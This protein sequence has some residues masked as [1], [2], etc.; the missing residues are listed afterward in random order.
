[1]FGAAHP[2]MAGAPRPATLAKSKS[3]STGS[4][5]PATSATDS[6]SRAVSTLPFMSGRVGT[7]DRLPKATG[8]TASEPVPGFICL[9]VGAGE[10]P[11][12]ASLSRWPACGRPARGHPPMRQA[13][14]SE[15]HSVG[16]QRQSESICLLSYRS[17]RATG[18]RR[19][20]AL[21]PQNASSCGW[22]AMPGLQGEGR[23]QEGHDS[24]R[25]LTPGRSH[26]LE[27][28]LGIR[29]G[30]GLQAGPDQG[31][32]ARRPP[33]IPFS[34]LLGWWYFPWG[35][36][37][38]LRALAMPQ[39]WERAPEGSPAEPEQGLWP[40]GWTEDTEAHAALT[41]SSRAQPGWDVPTWRPRLAARRGL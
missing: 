12:L 6:P 17:S 33:R 9:S 7:G 8:A 26:P 3:L 20:A 2:P 31:A 11:G 30:R 41:V 1:M 39:A 35:L 13:G 27:S 37:S 25:A 18:P 15:K 32:G 10:G 5:V 14:Q 19:K 28:A 36:V 21:G 16:A 22:R 4:C 23:G 38:P 24:E 29:A 34:S 40:A